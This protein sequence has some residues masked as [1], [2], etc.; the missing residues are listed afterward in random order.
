M[1]IKMVKKAF[2][3]IFFCIFSLLFL[4]TSSLAKQSEVYVSFSQGACPLPQAKN[5]NSVHLDCKSYH[6]TTNYT[7]GP[8]AIMTLMR[9]YGKLSPN[10]M[11]Q[12][13]EL[14]IALEMGAS[15]TGVTI[16]QLSDWLSGHGFS[17]DSGA[18]VSSAMIIGNLKK[19]IPTIIAVNQH[20][21]LAKGYTPGSTSDQDEIEFSDSCCSTSAMSVADIDAM[22]AEAHLPENHCSSNIGEYVVATPK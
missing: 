3:I 17:V 21:I 6:Q 16:T 18:N 1:K 19:G 10:E 8:A 14:R 20:W 4:S 7:C 12:K 15:D 9:Y 22:W 2:S 5:K 11:N 13:T